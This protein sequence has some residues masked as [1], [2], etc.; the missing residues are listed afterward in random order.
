MLCRDL[1]LLLVSSVPLRIGT[2][3]QDYLVELPVSGP[4][5]WLPASAAS[6]CQQGSMVSRGT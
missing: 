5:L 1:I 2:V 3:V 4:G 6:Q